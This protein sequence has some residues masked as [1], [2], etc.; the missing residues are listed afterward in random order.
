MVAD[1]YL[2]FVCIREI[3]KSLKLSSKKL[4]EDKIRALGVQRL[5]D[6]TQTEI[7]RKGTGANGIMAFQGMQDHTA[8]SVKS[9]EA[10]GRAWVEEAQNLSERS[11]TL[12]RPTI[13]APGSQIWASWNPDLPSDPVDAFFAGSP[14]NSVLVHVNVDD[15]PF[16]TQELLDEMELD[17]RIYSPE[18]FANVWGGEYNLTVDGAIYAAELRQARVEGRIT[19]VPY[20]PLLPVHTF[21][22][23]GV[24]DPTSIWFA[25]YSGGEIRIIDYYEASDLGL[26]AHAQVLLSKG[27]QYGK[28]FAPHD[29][30]VRDF[31]TGRTRLEA[32]A[33]L[34][35]RFEV[36]PRQSVEDGIHAARMMMPKCWFD[37][38]RTKTGVNSLSNYRRAYNTSMGEFTATPVHDH[39]SHAADAFRYMAISLT[40]EKP[41]PKRMGG[42]FGHSQ[43]WM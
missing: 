4:I 37:S 34:G 26:S 8:D 40:E 9:L 32:A 33:A 2:D 43:A 17:R 24:L 5:F 3:Q 21:W 20:D 6:I 14:N 36:V 29:I 19:E 27:Y 35:I 23:L 16:K 18:K 28:H 41:K 15:N 10:F 7:R 11:W 12:L 25:Q 38:I 31:S 13:R 42:N 1:P 39:T 22:D 30:Q